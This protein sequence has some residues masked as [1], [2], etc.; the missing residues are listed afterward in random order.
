MARPKATKRARQAAEEGMKQLEEHFID[1]SQAVQR[2]RLTRNVGL[3]H[4]HPVVLL[5]LLLL[6]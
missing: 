2:V 3:L 6:L 5:L 4:T 1:L